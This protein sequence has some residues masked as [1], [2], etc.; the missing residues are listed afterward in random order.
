MSINI[1]I[2]DAMK[3]LGETAL[4]SKKLDS[5]MFSSGS[6]GPGSLSSVIAVVGTLSN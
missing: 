2:R 5:V 3:T 6:C 4:Y 1:S